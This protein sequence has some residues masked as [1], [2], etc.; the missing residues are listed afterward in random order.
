E[1]GVSRL[2]GGL[3]IGFFLV[4]NLHLWKTSSSDSEEEP[5]PGGQGIMRKAAGLVFVSFFAVAAGAELTVN[6]AEAIARSLGVSDRVIG[7]SVVAIGTSLP[8]LAAGIA[9]AL[10]G[11]TEIGLGNV[12][13]SNVFNLLVAVG[14]AGVVRPFGASVEESALVERVLWFD[15]PLVL[16]FSLAAAVLPRA[17][18][19]GKWMGVALLLG[20]AVYLYAQ[21]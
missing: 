21:F 14:A 13:G 17:G 10:K 15:L 18:S 8:E 16:A 6:G 7:L 4:H 2:G 11:Q 20:Y 1:G 5:L 3:L 9:S 19:P 12:V